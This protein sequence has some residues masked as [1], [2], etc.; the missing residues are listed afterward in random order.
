MKIEF[1]DSKEKTV[2]IESMKVGDTFLSTDGMSDVCMNLGWDNQNGIWEYI[3]LGE[4]PELCFTHDENF[5][6]R[7]VK[8]KMIVEI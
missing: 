3:I 7:P 5:Q 1:V 2:S 4:C 6:V 8:S